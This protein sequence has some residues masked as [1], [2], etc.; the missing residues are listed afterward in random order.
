M[1]VLMT[2][3]RQAP[4]PGWT[5]A[6]RRYGIVAALA[7]LV[8]TLSAASPT[9]LTAR[10]MEN[11]FDSWAPLAIVALGVTV[12]LVCGSF[13]LSVAAIFSLSGVIVA[14]LANRS[15][16]ALGVAAALAAGAAIGVFNGL[17]VT[18]LR[19]HSFLATL[20]SGMAIG[21]VALLI[22]GGSIV[23]VPDEA[24]YRLG[25]GS[26]GEV[27][28]SVL[29]A[30][31]VAVVIGLVL[32]RTTFG[33]HVYAVGGNEP[34]A[35]VAGVKTGRVSVLAFA[36]SGTT[37]AMAGVLAASRTSSGDAGAGAGL[38]FLAITAAVV[39]GTS[40]FGG[41]GSAWRTIIGVLFLALIGNGFNLLELDSVY[42]QV[43]N[44]ALILAAVAL[45]AWSRRQGEAIA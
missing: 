13:D 6:A 10:N 30:A 8:I 44:G 39:G 12:V 40:I 42:Q 27:P 45:D 26:L 36:I 25:A 29:L 16:L 24:F 19:I 11:V 7:A 9:F 18:V 21:A 17:L 32:A 34:A 43:V 22:T 41:A 38:E 33:D 3:V 5:T 2:A 15:S 37:A 20:A 35:R 31:A 14:E 28:Y 23:S 4:R 1:N